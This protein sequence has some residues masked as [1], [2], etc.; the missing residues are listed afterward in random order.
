MSERLL[1]RERLQP[2]QLIAHGLKLF[3][4]FADQGIFAGTN[5]IL[6][7]L[8][9]RWLPT[10]EYGIFAI[11]F[12]GYLVLTLIHYG[13]ILE[14]LLV[15]SGKVEPGC[16]RSYILTVIKAHGL[17]NVAVTGICL[18]AMAI[19]CAV[20]LRTA[21]YG[22]LGA[23]V[24]GMMLLMLLTARRLCLKFLSTQI[25]ALVG[26]I[27]LTGVI[28]SAYLLYLDGLVTWQAIWAIQGIWALIC[29]LV[30]FVL[31]YRATS[32]NDPYSLGMLYRFQIRYAYYATAAASA[33]WLR[34]DCVLVLLASFVGIEAVA[35]TRAMFTIASPMTQINTALTTT[36][37]VQASEAHVRN[38]SLPVWGIVFGYSVA[39]AI[40]IGLVWWFDRELVQL[41]F[42]GRYLEAA[43]QLPCLLSTVACNGIESVLTSNLK[44]RGFIV[45]GYAPPVAGAVVAMILAWILIPQLGSSGAIAAMMG[46]FTTGMLVSML[47]YR[48]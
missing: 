10:G 31:L 3:W 36:W 18:V 1:A 2:A 15:Q 37:L 41:I 32:G 33:Q 16:Y 13:M 12:S 23:G 17:V 48:G 40:L 46:S 44:G 34:V 27:Y 9:A 14:P 24:G 21:G 19:L 7:V 30:I 26:L 38:Q 45:R 20:D 5:F 29:S 6:N 25:S 42:G 22:V 39:L 47:V 28:V 35:A 8:F 11:T 43:W 4:L